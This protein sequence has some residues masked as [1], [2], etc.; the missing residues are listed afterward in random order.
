MKHIVQPNYLLLLTSLL[1][2]LLNVGCAPK[3]AVHYYL[4][5][6]MD[7][8]VS[9]SIVMLSDNLKT[10]S[11]LLR[12]KKELLK[13]RD[14]SYEAFKEP[15]P[16]AQYGKGYKFI[17]PANSTVLLGEGVQLN[18]SGT[19]KVALEY[20]TAI[21]TVEYASA[22]IIQQG[23]KIQAVFLDIKENTLNP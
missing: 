14:E 12:H 2:T 16:Y 8:E 4:R 21:D 19:C 23:G 13:V 17:V 11:S 15:L 5:N 1:L 22:E 6:Y 7:K 3:A 20:G 18:C 9:V 10:N